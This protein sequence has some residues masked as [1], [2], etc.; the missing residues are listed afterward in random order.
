VWSGSEPT[1]DVVTR[2]A[3][4]PPAAIMRAFKLGS[5]LAVVDILVRRF[6]I[7]DEQEDL[8]AA[9]TANDEDM[10]NMPWNVEKLDEALVQEHGIKASSL[11]RLA[12]G[13]GNA[14]PMALLLARCQTEAKRQ[15]LLQATNYKGN[16][17]NCTT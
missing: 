1:V 12:G 6:L 2:H 5:P 9:T 17:G 15:E 8:F 13:E 11:F 10:I 14:G 4:V 7:T 3:G 16:T